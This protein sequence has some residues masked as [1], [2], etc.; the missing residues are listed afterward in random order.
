MTPE[1]RAVARQRY[2]A[3]QHPVA[4]IARTLGVSRASIYRHLRPA[5]DA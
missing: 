1:K 2:G 4:T 3:G 5:R